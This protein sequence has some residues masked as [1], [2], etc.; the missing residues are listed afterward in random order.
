[1]AP[2]VKCLQYSHEDKFRFLKP[3]QKTKCASIVP[4]LEMQR[5]GDAWGLLV[6]KSDKNLSSERVQLK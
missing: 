2:L 5:Q 4:E 3:T 1:M 6:R